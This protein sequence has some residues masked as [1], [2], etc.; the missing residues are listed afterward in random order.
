MKLPTLQRIL[1]HLLTIS[2]VITATGCASFLNN[3]DQSIAI[4]PVPIIDN[5][6]AELPSETPEVQ[7]QLHD[8]KESYQA[9][10]PL[11]FRVKSRRD[12]MS[13]EIVDPC[14]EPYQ[15]EIPRSNHWSYWVNFINIYGLAFDYLAGTNWR[16][17]KDISVPVTPI[18]PC[19]KTDLVGSSL[20]AIDNGESLSG[21][22]N[23]WFGIALV[24][25][26][27]TSEAFNRL[28]YR[29]DRDFIGYEIGGRYKDYI[30]GL[31]TYSDSIVSFVSGDHAG[32]SDLTIGRSI[33][34][35]QSNPRAHIIASVGYSHVFYRV[36]NG[37]FDVMFD[38]IFG[39]DSE[40]S[41]AERKAKYEFDDY[42]PTARLTLR[43]PLNK[44][45][46]LDFSAQ[47]YF[48][49]T[50]EPLVLSANFQ[51]GGF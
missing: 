13:F 39:I 42:G 45:F 12:K 28:G 21:D 8:G 6:N 20:P 9:K 31:H 26:S 40:E 24:E 15:R 2:L 43:Y 46:A 35:F 48:V 10:I 44:R 14:F 50:L 38:T 22:Y 19:K 16:Y 4:R 17:E 33:Y 23:L 11:E 1:L 51:F 3:S 49:D 27:L 7:I 32:V 30:I 29:Y 41:L 47:H 37:L 34:Q 25:V 36:E 18:N 5:Q